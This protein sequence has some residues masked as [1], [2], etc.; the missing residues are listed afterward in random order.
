MEPPDVQEPASAFDE[1]AA[2]YDRTF[3]DS[4]IGSL[5]RETVWRRLDTVFSAG[6]SVLEL[7]CGTGEDA[8]HLALRHVNVVATDISVEMIRATEAKVARYGL[9]DR[10]EVRRLAL[11]DLAQEAEL[12][13]PK[14]ATSGQSFDGALSNFGGLNC[15]QELRPIAEGL[16]SCVRP[17]GTA[18]LCVMGP[19]CPWEWAWYIAR[20]QPGKA[21]RRL[22]PGGVPWRGLTIRYPSIR[23]VERAFAPEFKLRR[24]MAVGT[25]I[26]PTYAESWAQ[27]HPRIVKRLGRWDRLLASVPPLPS[28]A[29]HYLLEMVRR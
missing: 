27:R 9:Q 21:F 18:L 15:A 28:L 25:L 22:R 20:M 11:E 3:S 13:R 12:L 16:A 23:A 19:L 10:V 29:D 6:Q 5:M 8:V 2:G 4:L 17:G 7:N 1:M 26:P 14:G 24:A